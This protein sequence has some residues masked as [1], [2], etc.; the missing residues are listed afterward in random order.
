M[1]C[2]YVY[3]ISHYNNRGTKELYRIYGTYKQAAAF[4]RK[5]THQGTTWPYHPRV[6]RRLVW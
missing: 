4:I 6:K 3:I 5:N 2:H 1:K